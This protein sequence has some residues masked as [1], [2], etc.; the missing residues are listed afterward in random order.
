MQDLS[1]NKALELIPLVVDGEADPDNRRAF[2]EYID[3][4]REVKQKYESQLRIKKILQKRCIKVR[5]PEHLKIKIQKFLK[6]QETE[7]HYSG[8]SEEIKKQMPSGSSFKS[9][10]DRFPSEI[11]SHSNRKKTI[12]RLAAAAVVLIVLTLFTMELLRQLSPTLDSIEIIE[13][14]AY[15]QFSESEGRMAMAGFQPGSIPEAQELLF[16]EFNHELQMPTI[17]GAELTQVMYSDFAPDYKTPVLE[18]YQ[19]GANEYIYVFAFKI[20]SLE[21]TQKLARDPDAVEKCRS[22]DDYHVKD[23]NGHHVVSW[24]WE[25]NW[26]VA[27][28]NHNGNDLAAIIKPMD[29]SLHMDN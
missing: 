21:K 12:Y 17:N 25:D 9:E 8:T 16:E 28:S 18:Y 27:V 10:P 5:A 23:I 7:T 4:D 15:T 13:D 22:Y 6:E 20:D 29:Q 2:L 1:K 11:P 19:E 14:F 3:S 24:K 26:Y